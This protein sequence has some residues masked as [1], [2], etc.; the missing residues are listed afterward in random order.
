MSFV[1]HPTLAS[2]GSVPMSWTAWSLS[3]GKQHPVR[4]TGVGRYGSCFEA[5]TLST[6]FKPAPR[7]DG[8]AFSRPSRVDEI[9]RLDERSPEWTLLR[10][11]IVPHFRAAV[12]NTTPAHASGEEPETESKVLALARADKLAEDT[13]VV[14]TVL[15]DSRFPVMFIESHRK[16]SSIPS[17]FDAE[18]VSYDGWFTRDAA[19]ALVPISASVAPL[20]SVDERLP[21]LTPIGILR[22]GVVSIWVMSEW[23]KNLKRMCCSR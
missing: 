17:D 23:G 8:L 10:R 16:F 14:D 11:E 7:S 18:A 9:V 2:R 3:T 22:L 13:V 19:G 15:N 12:A 4:V 20:S 5:I 21:R 6:S 1:R